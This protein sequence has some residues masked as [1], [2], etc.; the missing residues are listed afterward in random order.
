MGKLCKSL[1]RSFLSVRIFL[2][3][4]D[5]SAGICNP[6]LNKLLLSNML[7]CSQSGSYANCFATFMTESVSGVC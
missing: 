5:D 4:Q 1:Q 6:V 7:T 3:A 2:V